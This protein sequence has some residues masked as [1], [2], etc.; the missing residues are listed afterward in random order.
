VKA[1]NGKQVYRPRILICI[2]GP[3]GDIGA[4]PE[5]Q[6]IHNGKF[7]PGETQGCQALYDSV[8]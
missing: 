4:L 1:R 8:P 3:G 7:F 2:I 5:E 6:G